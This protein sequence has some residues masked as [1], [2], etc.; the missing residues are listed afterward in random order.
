VNAVLTIVL[1]ITIPVAFVAIGDWVR[2]QGL[3][4]RFD[5]Q[6]FNIVVKGPF[7]PAPISYSDIA[8]VII[9]SLLDYVLHT[10]V[11]VFRDRMWTTKMLPW[12]FVVVTLHNGRQIFL[13]PDDPA[14]FVEEFTRRVHRVSDRPKTVARESLRP[15]RPE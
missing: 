2:K 5:E 12:K 4:Y 9:V 15:Q 7:H 3:S 10:K 14:S 8:N 13:S 6:E 1:L 11:A